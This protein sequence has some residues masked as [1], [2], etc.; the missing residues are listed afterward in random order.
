MTWTKLSQ[1]LDV[2]KIEKMVRRK[3]EVFYAF[4]ETRQA[5]SCI[6]R[7]LS[8]SKRQE[9]FFRELEKGEKS[10]KSTFQE[11]L[12]TSLHYR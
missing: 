11:I 7:Q 5:E 2:P 4:R 1:R 8:A 3:V 6:L 12:R 10:R 9:G